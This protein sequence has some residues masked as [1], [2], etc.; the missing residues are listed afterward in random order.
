VSAPSR[1][2]KNLAAGCLTEGLGEVAGLAGLAVLAGLFLLSLRAVEALLNE[3]LVAAIVLLPIAAGFFIYGFVWT[4]RTRP[5][6]YLENLRDPARQAKLGTDHVRL[7][8][9]A[10]IWMQIV[11][12]MPVGYVLTRLIWH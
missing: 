12:L 10:M 11:C 6:L 5:G 1:R 2:P 7:R 8:K 9:V 3:Y 4:M